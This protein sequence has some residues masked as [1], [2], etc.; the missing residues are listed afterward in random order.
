MP[1]KPTI[2]TLSN[3]VNGI[4]MLNTIRAAASATYQDRIPIA[5]Q[6]NIQE[7]GNAMLQYQST[8]NEFL[9]ALINRIAMVLISSKL[10]ENPLRRF[11]KG[12]LGLGE[13]V[14][15]VF[16]NAA[17]A[18]QYDPDKSVTDLYKRVIPDV[19]AVFHR[20]NYQNYYKVTISNEQLRTAFLSAQG[21]EDLIGRIVDSL[22]TGANLDE[23]ILMKQLITN[24]V[25]SGQVTPVTVETMSADNAK[26]IITT[27]KATSN[28][29]EFMS[30][31]YNAMGV[32]T[33]TPKSKQILITDPNFDAIM[34]VEVLASA[35]N[36]SKAEFLGQRVM[37]DEFSNLTGAQAA[38]VD[39]DWFM[40]FDVYQGF[41][42]NYNGE[43]LYWNYF[44]H[45]WKIFSTSPFAN[46]V[47][48][49]T[50]ASTV[51]GITITPNEEVTASKGSNTQF[52][53]TVAGT[54]YKPAAVTWEV[55]GTNDTSAV[56]TPNGVL[57]IPTTE[58]NTTLTVK[59]TS[60]FNSSIS[61]S[62]T[63]T[64]S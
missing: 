59:A 51:T 54:G 16:I 49:T 37:I 14:E 28:A 18:R 33:Y 62:V 39:E 41:K 1:T 61:N 56:I 2:K 63:V 44:Y 10:Y 23:F 43:G 19:S 32:L 47:L 52:T 34:D 6:E 25:N 55:S 9:S 5:T 15:E 26:S 21:I 27:I 11:K 8:A 12:M 20:M 48:F 17:T 29:M 64:I 22:Y 35:F 45:L 4:D 31:K 38:L 36:M 13:S 58:T 40:V 57:S 30:N 50:Q 60:I 53:A 46:F 3:N 42:E 7:I 24:A